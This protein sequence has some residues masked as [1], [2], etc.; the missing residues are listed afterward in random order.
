MI[1]GDGENLEQE[2]WDM[3]F[4]LIGLEKRRIRKNSW[5]TNEKILMGRRLEYRN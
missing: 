3:L 2:A 4:R 1:K 5:N